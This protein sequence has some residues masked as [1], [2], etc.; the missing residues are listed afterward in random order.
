VRSGGVAEHCAESKIYLKSLFMIRYYYVSTTIK[1]LTALLEL[2]LGIRVV[3]KFLAASAKAQIVELL[4]QITNFIIAPFKSIF[5]NVVLSSGGVI[6][7]V[8]F[9]AMAGYF[10][11]VLVVLKLLK[12]IFIRP[13]SD[14]KPNQQTK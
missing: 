3:L 1:Y 4:Y 12:I 8:S 6:D 5:Q 13:V 10:I 7:L 2:L 9:S 14:S 11:F